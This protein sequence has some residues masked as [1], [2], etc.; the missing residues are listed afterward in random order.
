VTVYVDDAFIPATVGR[1]TARWCHLLSD[2]EDRTELHTLA[3]RI[4]LD[5]SWY[6]APGVQVR[7]SA[8]AWWRGHY[9]VT[10]AMRARAITFGAVPINRIEWGR[11]IHPVIE[12][13]EEAKR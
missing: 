13:V 7:G 8:D 12:R 11:L 1:T 6:Q 5:R 9:D 4:G 3:A 2:S 10:P